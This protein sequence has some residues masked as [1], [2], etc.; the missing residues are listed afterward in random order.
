MKLYIIIT[1]D[2]TK[3]LQHNQEAKQIHTVNKYAHM[4]SIKTK[5]LTGQ[6]LNSDVGDSITDIWAEVQ[7]RPVLRLAV[8]RHALKVLSGG[9]CIKIVTM[10]AALCLIMLI[11]NQLQGL[12]FSLSREATAFFSV[13]KTN[14]ANKNMTQTHERLRRTLFITT[15]HNMQIFR[16]TQMQLGVCFKGNNSYQLGWGNV[17]ER[18][19]TL[20]Q[21][22]NWKM[23]GRI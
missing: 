12:V 7:Q 8:R 15:K 5:T 23:R 9:H 19:T 22:Q 4:S 21:Q 6:D 13:L 14:G 18:N 3:W 17:F 2:K 10:N 20:K 1:K 11:V 16:V